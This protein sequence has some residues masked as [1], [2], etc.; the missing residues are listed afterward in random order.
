MKRRKFNSIT[1]WHID[2]L[3]RRCR[4]TVQEFENEG[5]VV[6]VGKGM[7]YVYKDRGSDILAVAHRD[8]V[9]HQRSFAQDGLTI[10]APQLDDRLGC[11]VILDLL[12]DLDYDI[13]LTEGEESGQSTAQYFQTDKHYKWMFEFDRT[14]TDCVMYQFDTPYLRSCLSKSGIRPGNGSFS[15]I[16]YLGHL[17]CSGINM[18]V[19]YYNYHSLEAYMR[20][21]H[22]LEQVGLFRRFYQENKNTFFHF[23]HRCKTCGTTK[24][25]GKTGF[26]ETHSFSRA[27]T[28]GREWNEDDYYSAHTA[29]TWIEQNRQFWR[30]NWDEDTKQVKVAWNDF[31]WLPQEEGEEKQEQLLL[32]PPPATTPDEKDENYDWSGL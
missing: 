30:N 6:E 27:A 11:H 29:T 31:N 20:I 12:I 19:G 28:G 15:D 23:L 17:G 7:T 14:G 2:Q 9:Q 3:E 16:A 32:L 25:V 26:C 13:L 8:T 18:G 22:L 10:Y 24:N 5:E 1:N 4:A 21:D